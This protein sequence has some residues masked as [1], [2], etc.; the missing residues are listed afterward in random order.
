[1]STTRR[2]KKKKASL[3]PILCKSVKKPTTPFPAHSGH[4]FEWRVLPIQDDFAAYFTRYSEAIGEREVL[5]AVAHRT[6]RL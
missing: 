6:P 2:Q 5:C 4:V 1:M 3:V